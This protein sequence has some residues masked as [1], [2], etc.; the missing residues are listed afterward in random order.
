MIF[1]VLDYTFRI[2]ILWVAWCTKKPGLRE[3]PKVSCARPK[4]LSI[5]SLASMTPWWSK[6]GTSTLPKLDTN[7]NKDG[8]EHVFMY[9]HLYTYPFK[10]GCFG[11]LLLNFRGST[12]L[13]LLNHILTH[14]F[15][16]NRISSLKSSWS[17]AS[18]LGSAIFLGPWRT[19]PPIPVP[20][21]GSCFQ[22]A[23]TSDRSLPRLVASHKKHLEQAKYFCTQ[24]NVCMQ[25]VF[26]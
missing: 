20:L 15:T 4:R 7:T 13:N 14:L 8:L 2:L 25:F 5:C 3:R 10:S 1:E 6:Y 18:L 11:Y 12:E 9:L 19:E 16:T 22:V 17:P 26:P 24:G 23:L 21:R